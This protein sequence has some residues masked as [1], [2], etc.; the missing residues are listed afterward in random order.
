MKR[1]RNHS[2]ID[3]NPTL[4]CLAREA[5][6]KTVLVLLL[7][8]LTIDDSKVLEL[9][10]GYTGSIEHLNLSVGP[11]L[12]LG[13]E[14]PKCSDDEKLGTHEQE[15]DSTTPIELIGVDEV[16]EDRREHESSKL[17]TYKGK[18]DC[19]GSG[20]LRSSLLSDSPAVAADSTSVEH[21]PGDHEY[22]KSSVGSSVCS[23]CN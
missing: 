6:E 9:A 2:L 17:L 21:G 12:S 15:H 22:Q 14:E 18:R 1:D 5:A 4:S 13:L 23:A 16:G 7:N 11:V 8:C 19:L 3:H 20:G 10:S